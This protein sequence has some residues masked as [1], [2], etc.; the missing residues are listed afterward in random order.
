MLSCGPQ[1]RPVE[2]LIKH[3]IKIFSFEIV[4]FL[5]WIAICLAGHVLERIF[6]RGYHIRVL[7][8]V[9]VFVQHTL[10]W[11][12]E[13]WKIDLDFAGINFPQLFKEWWLLPLLVHASMF[14]IIE[15]PPKS[16]FECN[17]CTV[18]CHSYHLQKEEIFSS[19]EISLSACFW[20][21]A[22]LEIPVYL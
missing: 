22:G 8:P 13:G 3:T 15:V 17:T 2:I 16:A 1:S 4:D 21:T 19:Q 6:Q 14:Q 12:K 9:C 18:A 20:I 7:L 5:L 11:Q 10:S